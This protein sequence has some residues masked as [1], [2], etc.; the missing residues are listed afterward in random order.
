MTGG[1]TKSLRD[2]VADILRDEILSVRL[3]PGSI[4]NEKVLAERLN[5][6][7][8]PVREALALLD[9]EGLVQTLPRKGYFVTPVTIQDISDAFGLRII[10]ECAA[11]E[12]AATKINDEDIEE[13]SKLSSE[14]DSTENTNE[15][16]KVNLRFHH[17]IARL[18]GNERLAS[19]VK[20][21][22]LDMERMNVFGFRIS[23]H[24]KLLSA[25]R[26]RDP[27]RAAEVMREQILAVRDKAAQLIAFGSP[28]A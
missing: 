11:A 10:L 24:E 15:R 6:S 8:T 9:H 2:Q 20:Q 3:K 7:K 21:L 26:Q 22:H 16:I 14:Y 13:L 17:Y 18:S 5:V 27:K 23:G 25:F 1:T 28:D 12:M 19:L 4:L